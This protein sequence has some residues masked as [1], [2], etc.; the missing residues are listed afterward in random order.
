MRVAGRVLHLCRAS[1]AGVTHD[2]ARLIPMGFSHSPVLRLHVVAVERQL[3]LSSPVRRDLRGAGATQAGFLE[4]FLN[5]LAARAVRFQVLARVTLDLRCAVLPGL[6]VITELSHTPRKLGSIHRGTVLLRTIELL[7][8]NRTEFSITRFRHVEEDQAI[9]VELAQGLE[10][11]G[12]SIWYFERD[13]LPVSYLE[14]IDEAIEWC[15]AIVVL[16]SLDSMSSW[17]VATGGH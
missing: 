5:L 12:Y 7:R 1:F 9:A 11:N 15:R 14:Q 8:L 4:V 10:A 2:S 3:L 17:Q 13:G 6:Q 16:V